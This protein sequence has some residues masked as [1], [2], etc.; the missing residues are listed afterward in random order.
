MVMA[1]EGRCMA[2]NSLT[3]T[4]RET[5]QLFEEAGTPRST[6]EVA[7]Q[8]DLGRRSAYGRLERLVD[9]GVLET[10]KVGPSARVWWRPPRPW[11]TTSTNDDDLRRRQTDEDMLFKMLVDAVEEYA[12]FLL[13][14][15]GNVRTW[16]Q[17][18]RQM[19]GYDADDIVGDHFSTFYTDDDR[20]AGVPERNL[21]DAT[22]HG[23]T[24][25]EGWRVRKDGSRFWANV[26]ITAIWDEQGELRGFT[27]V[28]RDQ[29]E[30]R[31]R[32]QALREER[33]LVDRVFETTPVGLGV[34]SRDGVERVNA[35][36]AEIYEASGDNVD[37]YVVGE[38][39]VFN[40]QG[41]P[42]PP[43]ERPNAR[44]FATGEPVTGWEC[45]LEGRDG[46]R[47]WLS[48]SAAPLGNQ[49]DNVDRVVV[50]TQDVTHYKKQ[51]RRLERQRDEIESELDEVLERVED[52]FCALD[53]EFRF[54]YVNEWA[55]EI[56]QVR[57]GELL[58]MCIW[59]VYPEATET[60]VWDGL[61][62]AI[63]TQ[64]TR[65]F[66]VYSEEIERWLEARV[67]PSET[68][69]S[70]Y[71]RDV[72]ERKQTE[73]ALRRSEERFRSL[74][75]HAPFSIQIFDSDG[76]PIETNLAW[77]QLWDAPREKLGDYNILQ[78]EQLKAAGLLPHI[79]DAFDGG[80][81]E[82]PSIHYDPA[83]I[84]KQGQSR[85]I[86]GYVY[87]LTSGEEETS[88]IALVHNDITER[89][90]R[91]RELKRYKNIV[92]TVDDGIYVVDPD[93]YLTMA[94][95]GFAELTGY[96]AERLV[97]MHASDLVDEETVEQARTYEQELVAG[98]RETARFEADVFTAEGETVRAEGMFSIIDSPDGGQKRVGVVRDVSE[99][100]ARE[101]QLEMYETVV[102]TIDDGIYVL[103]EEFHFT[104]VNEAYAEM[105]GYD[106]EELI[107][108]HCSLVVDDAV[109]E[110]SAEWL[111][112]IANGEASGATLEADLLRADGTSLRAESSFTVLPGDDLDVD[113]KVGVVRDVSE[114]VARE[115]ELERQRERLAALND[116]NRVV[117]GLTEAVIEQSTRTEIEQTVC[118]GLTA[119]DSIQF[120]WIGDVDGGAMTVRPRAEASIEDSLDGESVPFDIDEPGRSDLIGRAVKTRERQVVKDLADSEEHGRL[121]DYANDQGFRS[122]AV[123]PITHEGAI[124]GVLNVFAN[125]QG[126]F[127]GRMG[128]AIDHL[129]DHIGH[130]I[131]ALDQQRALTSD[132]VVEMEFRVPDVFGTFD[133]PSADGRITF[134]RAVPVGDGVYLEYG[135][136]TP[137][138]LEVFE[139]LVE[140]LPHWE[141]VQFLASVSGEEGSR[142]ELR[143]TEPPLLSSLTAIGGYVDRLVLEGGDF[144][145]R[146][147][148]APSA[149]LRR[150]TEVM[151]DEY[152]TAE[153]LSRRQ[154]TR[155]YPEIN[156]PSHVLV[157]ELTDRQ[158]TALEVAF[159]SGY[160]ESPRP[161]SG[162]QLA[163]T[164]GIAG[165]TF[166][167][168]LRNAQKTVLEH[169]LES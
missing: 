10:K 127:T 45:Q 156:P 80:V 165:P 33:D 85:W 160:F 59:D 27:K 70:V 107:G 120:A 81:V 95:D 54:T 101:R 2:S 136:A 49:P 113:W 60:P 102:S 103:D 161:V 88:E 142:F 66:E 61:H 109:A 86:E 128:D 90:E 87:P 164:I 34:L 63:E 121:M 30:R 71:F 37:D 52:A 75:E 169:V 9:R 5:L 7:A 110:E 3:D 125:S 123:I 1:I 43:A 53:E 38:P 13:D 134:D 57:S 12:I 39:E 124:Y 138:M 119:S 78:D 15:D 35:R 26:T 149:D 77:E 139:S 44:V 47:R 68:G 29:T 135:I 157:E 148:A 154:V 162:D 116:M 50:A 93:G 69:L 40:P 42:V 108:T 133:V 4:Q 99:R 74:M 67:Y 46:R 55:T 166:H 31:E 58:G 82:L 126:A 11:L 65:E 32:E 56:L 117:R 73:S 19:K 79:R 92:D 48:V 137:E 106:R 158:R 51:A 152:P 155:N 132:E 24:E 151:E 130:A 18:A 159:F 96:S 25:D 153:M 83:E 114:R 104:W 168:H 122:A 84:G 111:Q 98:E 17:G 36:A 94:N 21:V 140:N 28:T 167:Q 64:E 118:D 41:K 146:L 163:E 89:K 141:S 147:H 72:T 143:L 150:V 76:R 8:L 20:A 131:S 112:E 129:G 144:L 145:V 14:E 105:T 91:D 97:G 62:E 100:V 23:D 22:E 115:H 6:N 16:N